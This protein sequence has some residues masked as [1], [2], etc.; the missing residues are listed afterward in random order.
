MKTLSLMQPWATLVAVGAKHLETRSWSTAYR[1]PLLI[2]ASKRFPSYARDLVLIKPM[3][4]ILDGIPLPT[5]VV[6]AVVDLVDVMPSESVGCGEHVAEPER[7]FGDYSPGRFVWVLE[8]ERLLRRPVP[9]SGKLRLFDV[10]DELVQ[11]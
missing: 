3:S 4:T 11:L 6:I 1:G 8:N 2:H 10:P 9:F 7:S 5:G